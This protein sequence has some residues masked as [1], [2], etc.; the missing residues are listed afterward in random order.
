[1]MS[2]LSITGIFLIG[3]RTQTTTGETGILTRWDD[4]HDDSSP[5]LDKT[6]KEQVKADLE[7]NR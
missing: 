1:M 3:C 2:L 4:D 5:R 6:V 7:T